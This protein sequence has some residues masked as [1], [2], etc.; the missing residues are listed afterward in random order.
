MIT[1]LPNGNVFVEKG[2]VI[3]FLCPEC[4]A[5]VPFAKLDVVKCW[6]CGYEGPVEEFDNIEFEVRKPQ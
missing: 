1:R 2:T 3:P 4:E 6:A 5:V